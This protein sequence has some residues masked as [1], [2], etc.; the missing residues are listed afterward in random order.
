MKLVYCKNNHNTLVLTIVYEYVIAFEVHT[1]AHQI[2]ATP[3]YGF[4][5]R[6]ADN[7]HQR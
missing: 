5:K 1:G 6:K 4:L 2:S 7:T 3:W